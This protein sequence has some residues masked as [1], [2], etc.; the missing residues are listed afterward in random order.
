MDL[1]VEPGEVF[2]FLGP[3][4]AGKTTAIRLCSDAEADHRQSRD[5]GR[6][7]GAAAPRSVRTSAIC[8]V[9]CRCGPRER[10]AYAAVSRATHD[11]ARSR[12]R[13]PRCGVSVWMSRT[14]SAGPDLFRWHEAEARPR[15][16]TAVPAAS[17]FSRRADEGAR[18]NR[19][20]GLYDIVSET[21]ARGAT[22]FF[23]SHILPEV[24]RVCDRVAILRRG[25]LVAA[26]RST[27]CFRVSAG[28]CASPS[29]IRWMRA[30]S[31]RSA[32]SS[33]AATPSIELLVARSTV[34]ELTRHLSALPV[35]D[36]QSSPVW[37]RLSGALSMTVAT[38][39]A[40]LRQ[41]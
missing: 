28:A 29:R 21:R 14:A 24:E 39:V 35:R 27:R 5:L 30:A 11:Q 8:R 9:N 36:P 20:A 22:V 1:R 10:V 40:L 4:G 6:P 26:G 18:T 41:A 19:P 12:S 2:G 34:A 7:A 37:A 33:R 15:A 31:R 25:R 16:G 3:N 17:R 13:R 38:L 32:R 23:S